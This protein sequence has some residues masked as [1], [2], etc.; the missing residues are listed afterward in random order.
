MREAEANEDAYKSSAQLGLNW[1]HPG[2]NAL[3]HIF[4]QFH[5]SFRRNIF[6]IWGFS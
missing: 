3:R 5:A 4:T 1:P 2:T 6:R